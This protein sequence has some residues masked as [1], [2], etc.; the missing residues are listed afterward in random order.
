MAWM[1]YSTKLCYTRTY[2][3][4]DF[5]EADLPVM[6]LQDSVADHLRRVLEVLHVCQCE[7][8]YQHSVSLNKLLK[9][10]TDRVTGSTNPNR[11]HHASVAQL[12]GTKFTVKG[13]RLLELVWFDAT[14]EERLTLAESFH[15]GIER[16]L[17]L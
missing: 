15:Q 16:S 9:R 11:L 7:A 13:Q 1:L 8:G 6:S 14:N 10:M 3:Q 2:L 4:E 17:E 12:S 5:G